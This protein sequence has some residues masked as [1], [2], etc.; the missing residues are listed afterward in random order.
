[1]AEAAIGNNRVVGLLAIATGVAGFALLA[2][3]PDGEAKTFAEVLQ[4]EAAN[5]AMDAVVHGGFIAVLALQLV[6]Y[7][8]FSGRIGL[9][10]VTTVAGMVLFAVGSAFL[11]GSMLMDGLVLPAVAARYAGHPDKIELARTIYVLGG[12]LISFLMPIGLG[13][14]SAA[15][16]AWG[17]ALIG[18]RQRLAGL[19]GLTLGAAMLA[20]MVLG[21]ATM[22]PI[23]LMAGIAGAALWAMLAGGVMA[24]GKV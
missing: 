23:A 18:A 20:I 10:R 22:N 9:S 4:N 16:A 19:T 2:I 24:A 8:V 5:R 13:F 1:M 3:H 11:A 15:I 6:C 14:Q 21:L 12:T 17:S 7:A